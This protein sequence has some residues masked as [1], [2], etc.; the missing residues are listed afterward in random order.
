MGTFAAVAPAASF[1]PRGI[2]DYLKTGTGL[3]VYHSDNDPRTPVGGVRPAM[4]PLSG[5]GEDFV[6]TELPGREHSFPME[7]VADIFDYFDLH[8]R[9]LPPRFEPA[10]RPHSSFLR[11][12]SRDERKY[13]PA[14]GEAADAPESLDAILKDLRAG[15]GLAEQSVAKLVPS[16]DPTVNARV[17]KILVHADSGPDVRRFAA[18]VLEQRKAT[19]QAKALG[20]ALFLETE[21]NALLAILDALDAIADPSTFED[22]AKFLRVR[23]DLLEKKIQGKNQVEHSD[24]DSIL[25]S[26]ARACTALGNL[27]D[28]RG[29]EVVAKQVVEGVLLSGLEVVFDRQNQNPLPPAQALAEAALKALAL[30]REPSVKPLLQKLAAEP[31]QV[32]VS[33][34]QGPI[35]SMG[36]W[37][38]DPKIAALAQETLQ[39]LS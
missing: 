19:D 30:L 7:V 3:Y 1:G 5:S 34:L 16:A 27:K 13:L 39:S 37:K 4:E 2:S 29:A 26:L 25:P 12:V 20:R 15:G 10:V 14:L 17:G 31:G 22:V 38:R 28:P 11:K 36:G 33:V 24:W 6:Y 21:S 8:R 23:R 9:T 35:A 32:T 18:K